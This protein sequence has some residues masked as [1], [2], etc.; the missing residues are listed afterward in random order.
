MS[1]TDRI[2]RTTEA[3]QISGFCDMHLR[4]LEDAGRFPKRFKLDAESGKFGA[5]GWRLSEIEKWMDERAASR[6]PE[7]V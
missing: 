7:P 5:V 6:E 2:I 1:T 4:R 3:E